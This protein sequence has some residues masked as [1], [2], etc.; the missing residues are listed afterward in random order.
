MKLPAIA[1][2]QNLMLTGDGTWWATWR[3]SP[4]SYEYSPQKEKKRV[5]AHHQALFQ[6]LRGEALLFGLTADLDPASVVEQMI[7]GVDI[8]NAPAWVEEVGATLD[9]LESIP[10]GFRAFWLSVPLTSGSPLGYVKDRV[11]AA[12]TD[13]RDRLALPRQLP[14]RHVIAAVAARAAEIERAIP[15]A[16]QPTPASAAEQVWISIHSQQRGIGADRTVP[17]STMSG[18]LTEEVIHTGSVLSAPWLDE[19]GTSDHK[20]GSTD[21]MN[22]FKRRYL[23]VGSTSEAESYQVLQAITG[24]PHGGVVFPGVE[25]LSFLDRLPIDADWALRLSIVSAEQAK[26]KNRKAETSLKEQYKQREGDDDITG[27]STELDPIARTC[28]PTRKP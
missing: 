11:A 28:T 13:L 25:W 24:V 2:T 6:A 14:P 3:L 4:M 27:S 8:H 16:F 1:L 23:K 26:N 5:K 12:T 19:G 15:T 17:T 21:N 18:D 7:Q 22:P 20:R 10:L 9:L